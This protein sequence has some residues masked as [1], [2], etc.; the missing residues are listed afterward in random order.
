M[1]TREESFAI[2]IIDNN[3]TIRG[4][5]SHFGISKST[6]HNDISK[7]LKNTNRFLYYQVYKILDNNLKLRHIRGGEATKLMYKRLSVSKKS[8][9]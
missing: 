8:N 7:K 4:C 2:Y 1:K 6:V 5:A 9:K 3:S